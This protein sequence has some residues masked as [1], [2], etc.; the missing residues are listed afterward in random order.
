[1]KNSTIYGIALILGTICMVVTIF[2]HPTSADILPNNSDALHGI[3]INIF[4]HSIGIAGIPI[5]LLGFLGLSQILGIKRL[6]IQSALIAHGFGAIA[7]MCAAVFSGFAATSLVKLMMERDES[8]RT[9]LQMIFHYNGFLNQGFAKV[10]VVSSSI[11][12]FGWSIE[13]LKISGLAKITGVLG[14]LIGLI[15][16]AAFLLGF[17]R[18]NVRGFGLFVFAQSVWIVLTAIWMIN[19]KENS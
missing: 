15:S 1:M 3:Q 4:A 9:T 13:L 11:A 18:L 6:L 19:F 2:T 17:L 10:I 8:T 7:G 12:V 14:V 16:L 5:S